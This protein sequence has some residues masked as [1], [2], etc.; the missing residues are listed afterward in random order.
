MTNADLDDMLRWLSKSD[1]I[2]QAR[3]MLTDLPSDIRNIFDAT[4]LPIEVR[5]RIDAVLKR[6]LGALQGQ[7]ASAQERA[8]LREETNGG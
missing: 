5:N 1:G 3:A 4:N 8:E 7:L 2:R 6:E